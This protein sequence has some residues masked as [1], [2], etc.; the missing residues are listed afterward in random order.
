[1]ARKT[2]TKQAV[3]VEEIVE[4]EPELVSVADT[5][6]K[7]YV[8]YAMSVIV[9]RAL[10]DVR[11]GFKPVHR[12]I[13]YSMQN[14]GLSANVPHKK[15]ATIVGDVLGHYHPHGDASVYDALVRLGQDFSMRY[16]L[17]D[18]HGNFGS[19]DGDQAAAYRYTEARLT[20]LAAEMTRD[21][22]KDTVD[23]VPNF[24]GSEKEP[25]VLPCRFPNL[26]VNGSQGIAVGM[27]CNIPPHNL[28]EV[29]DAALKMLKNDMKGAD[30]TVD[31]MIDI[32][33][34]PDFP[35]GAE[36]LGDSWK[37]IYR[38]GKGSVTMQAVYHIEEDK[39]KSSLVFTELPYQVN[40]RELVESIAKYSK[41]KKLDVSDVRDET[42]RDGIRIVVE[43]KNRAI[44][45]LVLNNL[46]QHTKL[47]CNFNANMLCLVDGRPSQ[48]NVVQFLRYYIDHQMEVV[49]RRTVF[50]KKKAKKR[51]HIVEG[52]LIAIDHIDEIINIIKN[53]VDDTKDALQTLMDTF[54]LSE[55]QAQ[56]ILDMR[57]RALSGL[58]RM[59]LETEQQQ[60]INEIDRCDKV[61]GDRKELMK[62]VSKELREVRNKYGN[63]RKTKHVADYS[64]IRMED[65][66]EDEE[67]VVIRTK[68]GYLKR[69][70]PSNLRLQKRGGKGSHLA[71]I[72]EDY[73]EDM[74]STTLLSDILFFSNL[75]RVYSVPAYKLAETSRQARGTA[76]VSLLKLQPEEYITNMFAEKDY[77][78]DMSL[79]LFT[80]KGI[81]KRVAI[82]NIQNIR[83]NGKNIIKL[84]ENDEVTGTLIVKND[85]FIQVTTKFGYCAAYAVDNIRT[86]GTAARG[87]KGIKL[88]EGDE[89]V[90]IQK[91]ELGREVMVITEKGYAKRVRCDDFT[92]FVGRTARGNRC[93]K[94]ASMEKVGQIAK[95]FLIDDLSN[96]LVITM[97]NGQII[98]TP[99]NKVPLYSRNAMGLRMINISNNPDGVVADVASTI[100]EEPND[101]I[102]DENEDATVDTED[103][104][105]SDVHDTDVTDAEQAVSDDTTDST[106][107]DAE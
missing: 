102:D 12:R 34:G 22:D 9:A 27:A 29:C 64:D 52:L 82:G 2:K 59:K 45:E 65:L 61:L 18:G 86:M 101:D 98:K 25:A 85:D 68:I 91:R 24:D 38:T 41:L 14:L 20:K 104:V 17:V 50:E 92:V 30:T 56:T 107:D 23:W 94:A 105:S 99:I 87:V 97:D 95:V 21:M 100:H 31:E 40:K 58:G 63:D 88:T 106:S 33:K 53:S 78:D 8:D 55:E 74:I 81:T 90:S 19:I 54:G 28:T 80:K 67:C 10:P 70:K 13:I 75:G 43:L 4:K 71:T 84:D 16:P 72:N 66:I 47:R 5:L 1:M 46:L 6:G 44:P 57:L 83:I 77:N 62:L 96:D 48:L 7:S 89:V 76:I 49:S 93:I 73:V 35:T 103:A 11:D 79:L 39:K 3:P 69:M 15:C 37:D 42:D 51:L 26:L 32:I 36:M 60:L